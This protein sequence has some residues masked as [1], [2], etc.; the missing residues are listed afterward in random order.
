MAQIGPGS[1]ASVHG[2]IEAPKHIVDTPPGLHGL[3]KARTDADNLAVLCRA[4]LPGLNRPQIARSA[5]AHLNLGRR[6]QRATAIAGAQSTP[7][8][9]RQGPPVKW[10]LLSTSETIVPTLIP[11]HTALVYIGVL[12]IEGFESTS[13]LRLYISK[14]LEIAQNRATTTPGT[15]PEWLFPIPP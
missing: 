14:Y 15:D 9:P 8:H 1:M 11:D 13:L 12:A 4:Q 7:F 3:P 6:H 2:N 5:Q 10:R